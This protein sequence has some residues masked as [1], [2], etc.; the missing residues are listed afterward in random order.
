MWGEL[1][2][3]PHGSYKKWKDMVKKEVLGTSMEIILASALCNS[4]RFYSSRLSS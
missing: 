1:S 3:E 2:V 4:D